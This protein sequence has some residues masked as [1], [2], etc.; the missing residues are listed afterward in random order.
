MADQTEIPEAVL[1][2]AVEAGRD[3][4]DRD[5]QPG[6]F[7]CCFSS[8]ELGDAIKAGVA[9]A[10]PLLTAGRDAEIT[11]LRAEVAS[12]SHDL[13]YRP[14]AADQ[15]WCDEIGDTPATPQYLHHLAEH[16][17]ATHAAPADHSHCGHPDCACCAY[18]HC[19]GGCAYCVEP[20][21]SSVTELETQ[22]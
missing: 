3:S 4:H 6:H 8:L 15:Q 18:H 14:A 21:P 5:H 13:V 1:D 12:L 10:A 20:G 2:A 9:A 17:T 22:A 19:A 16:I 7:D 11:R